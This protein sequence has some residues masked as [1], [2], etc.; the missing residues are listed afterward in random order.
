MH[1]FV[2]LFGIVFLCLLTCSCSEN[3][4]YTIEEIKDETK[5]YRINAE[6]I[7]FIT[8]EAKSINQDIEKETLAYE[9]DFKTRVSDNKVTGF[10]LP[11]MQITHKVYTKNDVL[12]STVCEKYVYISGVHGQIWWKARNFDIKNNSYLKLCDLFYDSE[13][14]KIINNEMERMA[15]EDTEKYH[16]LWEKPEIKNKDFEN[17]YLTDKNLVIY[18]QP[19]E[20][21]FYAKGVVEFP[22]DPSVLR[23]YIKE[24]YLN[25]IN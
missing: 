13:Y 2:K 24:E 6:K 15:T 19:Y 4:G 16:D 14:K 20:L 22:I 11:C 18:F 23:G 8:D 12:I 25:M 1:N 21:S 7:T 3:P 9:E 5:D 10:E 17:F